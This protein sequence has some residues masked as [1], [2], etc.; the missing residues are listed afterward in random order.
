MLKP[1]LMANSGSVR[2]RSP[3]AAMNRRAPFERRDSIFQS[4]DEPER[5]QDGEGQA[6]G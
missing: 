3:N 5:G 6:A 2:E 4:K 1:L